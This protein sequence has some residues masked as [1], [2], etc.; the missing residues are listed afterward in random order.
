MLFGREYY[1]Q[2]CGPIPYER[3]AHW[4]NFFGGIADEIIRSLRPKRAFDAGC[5]WG[6]LVESFHDRGVESCGVDISKYAIEN[7]RPDIRRYCSLGSLADPIP[8]GRYDLVTCI[9][10]LEHMPEAES[11]MAIRQ[12][13][14]AADS[15]LFS[16]S[17]DDFNEPT[18]VNVHPTIFWLRLFSEFEF[19]PDINFNASFVAPHAFLVKK[20]DPVSG[21]VLVLFSETLRLRGQRAAFLTR[22]GRIEQ[23]AQEV[24][25][26][27]RQAED[28]SRQS[29]QQ[30]EQQAEIIAGLS[31]E[32]N[33]WI[34]A[35]AELGALREQSSRIAAELEQARQVHGRHQ[36]SLRAAEASLGQRSSE[37][38]WWKEEAERNDALR[39]Q[40]EEAASNLQY[41]LEESKSQAARAEST[42]EQWM[43]HSSELSHSLETLSHRY[44]VI[45]TEKE[46]LASSPGWRMIL[47]YREW[48]RSGRLRYS[49]VNKYWEPSLLWALQRAK[50]RGEG[51]SSQRAALAGPPVN[52]AQ[53]VPDRVTP[54]F[55]RA[56]P[57]PAPNLAQQSSANDYD[58]WIRENEPDGIRLEI[59]RRMADCFSFRPKISVI[60][61]VFK[62]PTGVLRDTID[63]VLGQTY[64]NWELCV[65]VPGTENEE[66][67]AY[68]EDGALREPRIKIK[69]LEANEG[70]S[71]NSNQ[72]LTLATGE[73]I[74]LLDH[75]DTLAPFALF[76][77][78]QLLNQDATT[79]FIYS[80]KDQISEDGRRRILPLFKPEWSPEILLNANYLTHLC[81]MRTD[82]VRKIGGWRT[83]TDG[84]QDWDLFLRITRTFGNIR[85]IPK[86]LYHWRQIS[87]SVASGGLQAKPYA[88]Q[89]QVSSVGDYCRAIGL[90]RAEVN[91]IE[92]GLH[93]AWPVHA[94]DRVSVVY[95][96]S[97]PNM[98]TLARAMKLGEETKHANF[99]ILIPMYGGASTIAP[100]RCIPVR[101]DAT[102]LE[103]IELAI[104][105][106]SGGTLVFVDES[107]SPL[108][109]DWLAELVGPLQMRDIGIVGAKLLDG[110]TRSLRHCGIVITADGRPEYIYAGQ[111]E[112]VSE[113]AGTAGWYRN[114]SA[115]S[116]A[117]FAI[118]RSAWDA[119][120]GMSGELLHSRLDVHLNLKLQLQTDLRILYNPYARMLND[121]E[122]SLEIPVRRDG[123][124]ENSARASF[125]N[126]D[127]YFS[128]NL[129][130]RSGKVIYRMRQSSGAQVGP[131]YSTESQVLVEIFD[132][133]P[134]QVERSK[135]LQ[136]KPGKGQLESITWFLPEFNNA[137]YGGVHTLLRFADGFWRSHKLRSTFCTLGRIPERRVRAQVA[138]AFP[139][140][141]A[142]STFFCIDA[143]SKV[144]QLPAS[145]AAVCSLWTTAYAALEFEK[146]RR[147]FY[148]I[149]DDE[150]LFYPAGSISA[151]VEATYRF[152]FHGIC[153]TVSLLKNYTARGGQGEFFTPCVDANVFHSRNRVHR[154]PHTLFCYGRPGHPRNSF[155]L[156]SAAL[157]MLKQRMGEDLLAIS[158]GAEW[159]P[160]DYHL[161]GVVQNLGILSYKNTG[162][163][164]R[165]CDAGVAIMMT[166]H[167]SYLPMELMA[168]GSLVVT[169][170]N[171]DTAW[172]LKDGENCLLSDLS[173]S[174]LADRIQ[175]G[176]ENDSLRSQ[177]T[178]RAGDFVQTDCG[179]WE[180]QIE[181]IYG[182][183]LSLC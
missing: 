9:E 154:L 90:T 178:A 50:L 102:L 134:A 84:A 81:I 44:E 133:V 93:I 72:A 160:R 126:G 47:R 137:F 2:G 69:V 5:A 33:Q 135:R 128:P 11:R 89:G 157:R 179:D 21:D 105:S 166:R 148:F 22:H 147:K 70:I 127:P 150:A 37:I 29:A 111:P 182:F 112:H 173:P 7:T 32:N 26:L 103:R 106:A 138:A 121:R 76:E 163:L 168:C 53:P 66:A 119:V 61:P 58:A 117:C 108:A 45:Q 68:L 24:D 120:K 151:L 18:H 59:Q 92:G 159:E 142:A 88:A 146:A 64:G 116:G 15:I 62:V 10:V 94:E 78:V 16:S 77:V 85:H 165:M 98:E 131:N 41:K 39:R 87:T 122:S 42:A 172:L 67:R 183:M 156:L 14:L 140:L 56:T 167:P 181:R 71:G 152:G 164:Y 124:P 107:V 169:N 110:F 91:H 123:H 19:Y 20:G 180:K 38:A 8:G 48:L 17:P 34:R 145:D 136:T 144:N 75:D 141:A 55:V 176:L 161:D 40:S 12:M 25:I 27:K 36:E 170:R 23:L 43:A 162:A 31:G 129:D 158:A 4:L 30:I 149:Q 60:V 86:V 73:Y 132:F 57:L 114:W 65:T 95:L 54:V 125:P 99:E 1:R 104:E 51:L 80:D 175:E 143:Q 115:V 79:N 174:S 13:T 97:A 109:S 82:Q 3:N 46:S 113:Q 83:E 177:I 139:E 153:N 100:V 101:A 6:F 52:R 130:C 171:P 35:E 63:S 28:S 74:A 49:W 155:E 96:S 118:R